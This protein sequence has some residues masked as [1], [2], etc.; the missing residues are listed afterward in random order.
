MSGGGAVEAWEWWWFL[1]WGLA[2]ACWARTA[3]GWRCARCHHRASDDLATA[4]CGILC[5]LHY[6]V[7]ATCIS[8]SV[9]FVFTRTVHM[10]VMIA[11]A[12]PFSSLL[13]RH[14]T[15]TMDPSHQ[16]NINEE[17]SQSSIAL[18]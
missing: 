18:G 11:R 15:L 14:R 7:N 17:K 6:V 16:Y 3:V 2:A 8:N 13:A 12:M 5:A 4:C 9:F 1:R 10:E